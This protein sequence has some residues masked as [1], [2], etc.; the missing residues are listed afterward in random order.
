V[1]RALT[2][3]AGAVGVAAL[4]RMRSRRRAGLAPAPADPADELRRKLAD[5]RR[6]ETHAAGD[7]V[8][9]PE[10][11]EDPQPGPVDL[12]ERRARVHARAQEAIEL[13]SDGAPVGEAEEDTTE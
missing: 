6:D 11:P 7:V 4:A 3:L 8:S 2:W 5:Q 13:M 1:R 10:P 9:E 12:E